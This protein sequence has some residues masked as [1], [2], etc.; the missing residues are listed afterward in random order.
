MQQGAVDVNAVLDRLGRHRDLDDGHQVALLEVGAWPCCGSPG[1]TGRPGWRRN[2]GSCLAPSSSWLSSFMSRVGL[3][4]L[5][6]FLGV[7]AGRALCSAG[8]A[9]GLMRHELVV[10]AAALGQ[11]VLPVACGT[12]PSQGRASLGVAAARR[13]GRQP[14]AI[15]RS[16]IWLTSSRQVVVIWS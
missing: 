15:C 11:V 8:V 10:L 3:E 14:V 4:L 2:S 1:K 7:L 16:T 9:L 6:P 12:P 13:R 5:E